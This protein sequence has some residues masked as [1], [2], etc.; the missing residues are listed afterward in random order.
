MS[1][2]VVRLSQ[3]KALWAV[4]MT[5]RLYEWCEPEYVRYLRVSKRYSTAWSWVQVKYEKRWSSRHLISVV[6][7]LSPSL[8]QTLSILQIFTVY[9]TLST[10]QSC[11]KIT[12]RANMCWWSDH[13]DN[14]K[15]K[16]EKHY[17]PFLEY[18]CTWLV[19]AVIGVQSSIAFWKN[20]LPTKLP[21]CEKKKKKEKNIHFIYLS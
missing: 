14:I 11:R 10:F 18:I 3:N 2:T 6:F 7:F 21:I 16:K 15:K 9:C 17:L 4:H 5:T 1:N 8:G 19:T 20:I 13:D 12:N